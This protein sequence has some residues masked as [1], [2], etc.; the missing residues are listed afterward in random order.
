M[1][2]D[3]LKAYL[4]KAAK[5][6]DKHRDIL[7]EIGRETDEELLSVL[8][9]LSSYT[10]SK[11]SALMT[12]A[13]VSR[14][15]NVVLQEKIPEIIESSFFKKSQIETPH[16]T[17]GHLFK[18]QMRIL[19]WKFIIVTSILLFGGIGLTKGDGSLLFLIN[20]APLLASLTLLY[21]HRSRFYKMEE[22]EAACPFSPAYV[23]AVRI[24]VTLMYTG[25]L[26]FVATVLIDASAFAMFTG[27]KILL[28]NMILAW[29]VPMVFFLGITLVLSLRAGIGYGSFAAYILWLIQLM[30]EQN[31]YFKGFEYQ[32]L[33]EMPLLFLCI[34]VLMIFLY[35]R[36]SNRVKCVY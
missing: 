2:C 35:I 31:K 7:K 21:E 30:C 18:A 32:W 10:V 12:E 20:G 34:G 26:C 33:Q 13:L 11:P 16:P 28:G 9:K 5:K 29:L 1:D 25:L 36:Y 6:L 15:K 4:R 27:K 19:T 8:D 24:L 22:M 17:I 3:H 23:A 14:L